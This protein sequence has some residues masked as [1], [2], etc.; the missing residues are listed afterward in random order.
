MFSG[1][2][3]DYDSITNQM[4]MGACEAF[5][6]RSHHQHHR[7]LGRNDKG[8]LSACIFAQDPVGDRIVDPN[9]IFT[10]IPFY[11]LGPGVWVEENSGRES[12]GFQDIRD[13]RINR[14]N[15]LDICGL[16]Q[17]GKETDIGTTV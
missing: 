14:E 8:L 2:E 1:V 5:I 17:G 12:L 9:R 3:I 15:S 10:H 13:H 4:T 6:S 7:F 16:D 11:R